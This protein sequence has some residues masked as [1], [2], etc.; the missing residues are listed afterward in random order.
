MSVKRF[1]PSFRVRFTR[2]DAHEVDDEFQFHLTMR[3]RE[4]ERAG[5]SAERAREIALMEFG[6]IDD[7]H[8]PLQPGHRRLGARAVTGRYGGQR[9]RQRACFDMPRN[10]AADGAEPGD[11]HLCHACR[12]TASFLYRK[13]SFG[14]LCISKTI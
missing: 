3:A 7:G 4:L 6:D 12:A 2:A 9:Q 14:G 13:I 11:A 10:D 1:R 5:L 8:R